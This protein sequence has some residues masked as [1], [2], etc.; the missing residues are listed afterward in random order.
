MPDTK[1]DNK[2]W[3]DREALRRFWVDLQHLSYDSALVGFVVLFL[4][5]F[6]WLMNM[7]PYLT[8]RQRSILE[9]VHFWYSVALV[10]LI[11]TGTL[12]VVA[13]RICEMFRRK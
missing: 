6:T 8:D 13:A 12:S 1:D 2:N 9:A 11:A 7:L 3:F 10:V 5:A 4:T